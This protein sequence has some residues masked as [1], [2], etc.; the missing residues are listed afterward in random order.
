MILYVTI[1]GLANRVAIVDS[2]IRWITSW[3]QQPG[4]VAFARRKHLRN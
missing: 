1:S 4:T 3:E 2:L